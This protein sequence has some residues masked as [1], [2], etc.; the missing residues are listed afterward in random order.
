MNRRSASSSRGVNQIP[1]ASPF[2]QGTHMPLRATRSSTTA[3]QK[4]TLDYTWET[5]EIVKKRKTASENY[6]SDKDEY[7]MLRHLVMD[8]KIGKNAHEM[9]SIF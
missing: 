4:K 6:T 3:Q 5:N 9:V 1:E 7:G 2:S 8:K